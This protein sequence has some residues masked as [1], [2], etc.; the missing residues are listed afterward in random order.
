MISFLWKCMFAWNKPRLTPN[1]YNPKITTSPRLRSLLVSQLCGSS[2]SAYYDAS[3]NIKKKLWVA[4]WDVVL[5]LKKLLIPIWIATRDY[6]DHKS[7]CRG[8]R[9]EIIGNSSQMDRDDMSTS[10][11]IFCG[12][13]LCKKSDS[14]H[15]VLY[16]HQCL[17]WDSCIVSGLLSV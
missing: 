5:V 14:S 8:E 10:P 1:C 2:Q 7:S 13:Y 12:S 17:L 4:L 3:S 15:Q 16:Y 11:N 9:M 6:N